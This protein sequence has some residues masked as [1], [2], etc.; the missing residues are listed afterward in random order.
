MGKT[1]KKRILAIFVAVSVMLATV[2]LF[3]IQS[4]ASILNPATAND[5][6]DEWY[7]MGM[8][9]SEFR[10]S[11][12]WYKWGDASKV[13]HGQGDDA[14]GVYGFELSVA[15]AFGATSG[16]MIPQVTIGS[17]SMRSTTIAYNA[18]V[19]NRTYRYHGTVNFLAAE[20]NSNV[21][22][23]AASGSIGFYITSL[24]LLDSAGDRTTSQPIYSYTPVEGD[25]DGNTGSKE[26]RQTITNNRIQNINGWDVEAWTQNVSGSG[27]IKM[28]L[29][30]DGT[31][32]CEW[33]KTYNTLFRTG[34]KWTGT[35][36]NTTISSVGEIEV[37]YGISNYWSDRGASY[38]GIYGWTTVPS[39]QTG[40]TVE[41]YIMDNWQNWRPQPNTSGYTS[42]GTIMVDG[43]TYDIITFERVN[44]PSI[45]DERDTFLQIFS[46]RRTARSSGTISVS[47]H[48]NRWAQEGI[49]NLNHNLYE[50]A[51]KIEGF[52]G[53]Q[54]SSG[55]GT[56]DSLYL[57]Y[58]N[59]VMCTHTSEDASSCTY[60]G[61]GTPISTTTPAVTSTP[62]ATTTT[63]ATTTVPVTTATTATV[64]VT[65]TAVSTSVPVT[66]T[67]PATTPPVTTATT[68]ATTTSAT[69]TTA[70]TNTN[71]LETTTAV[72]VTTTTPAPT[73]ASTTTTSP[74]T[75][76][77]NP[78]ETTTAEPATTSDT[79]TSPETTTAATVTTIST[80]EQTTTIAETT[81]TASPAETTVPVTTATT[82]TGCGNCDRVDC[83][84]CDPFK[85]EPES[86][87]KP[88]AL[89]GVRG[90]TNSVGEP[91]VD[92]FDVLELLKFIVGMDNVMEA[93][94]NP[95]REEAMR[96]AI[97]SEAGENANAPTIFCVLEILKYIVNMD[98]RVDGIHRNGKPAENNSLT[99]HRAVWY[100]KNEFLKHKSVQKG[101]G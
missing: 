30:T 6:Q 1:M 11:G 80:H 92:I 85:G 15:P 4:S 88:L 17:D 93:S 54:F 63:A 90:T 62:L 2:H 21:L 71:P 55:R 16:N 9:G 53:D 43:G 18:S 78:I 52:G 37:K 58:G 77:A 67:T 95:N 12:L 50:V 29:Y 48:F 100:N 75:T 91:V 5:F 99:S 24:Y 44:E 32:S 89:G 60:C 65:T 96:A 74:T 47:A 22:I 41:Y 66:T 46:I 3:G 51:M 49:L 70:A 13:N 79:T 76:T 45:I 57:K 87:K 26:I 31:F 19:Q 56:L 86:G 61:S 82:E 84:L 42:H 39:G 68:S 64:S 23:R 81:T 36:A 97:I 72:S 69:A 14:S 35:Q 83:E 7:T 10:S 73:T 40:Q 28:E 101:Q 8:V 25:T 98:S 94:D 33:D 27:A 34:K 59:T 38:V 20:S